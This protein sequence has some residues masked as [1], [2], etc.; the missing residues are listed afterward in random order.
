MKIRVIATTVLLLAG[1]AAVAAPEATNAQIVPPLKIT[2]RPKKTAT[3]KPNKASTPA[4]RRVSPV[5]LKTDRMGYDWWGRPAA[6][7]AAD[8][9]C[10]QLDDSRRTLRLEAA[11]TI[12]NRS[13]TRLSPDDY[14]VQFYKTDGK[15]ALT[16][17]WLYENAASAPTIE[18]GQSANITFMAFVEPNERVAYAQLLTRAFGNGNRVNVASNLA[19]PGQ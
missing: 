13:S 10:S 9:K 11:F 2:P 17:F 3:P 18:P 14:W 4:P 19:I 7:D 8:G 12:E 6:M 15:K 5:V 1:L 16:C